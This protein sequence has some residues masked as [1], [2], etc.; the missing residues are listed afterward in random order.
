[1]LDKMM[2][3]WDKTHGWQLRTFRR[4]EGQTTLKECTR[5]KKPNR[6]V[7]GTIDSAFGG[8]LYLCQACVLYL[9]LLGRLS[10]GPAAGGDQASGRAAKRDEPGRG[11]WKTLLGVYCLVA[12]HDRA[13]HSDGQLRCVRC[14]RADE[15]KLA[16]G[17]RP[18]VAV[19]LDWPHLPRDVKDNSRMCSTGV[20]RSPDMP[21]W[22][23]VVCAPCA[24]KALEGG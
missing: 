16:G 20:W 21:E 24:V 23:F 3:L 5:C 19:P 1:V 18:W 7:A 15:I 9:Q 2:D 4:W 8:R 10:Q 14:A 6:L 13:V 12:G 11:A 17:E 22:G